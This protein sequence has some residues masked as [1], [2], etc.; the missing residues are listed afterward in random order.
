MPAFV[1]PTFTLEQTRSVCASACGIARSNFLSPEVKPFCT[2]AE[3]PPMKSTP[4]VFAALSI[5]RAKGTK[6]SV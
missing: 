5:V 3:K 2:S 4:H 1:E 6:S